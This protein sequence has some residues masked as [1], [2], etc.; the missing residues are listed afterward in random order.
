MTSEPGP[1]E[2]VERIP[3]TAP[4]CLSGGANSLSTAADKWGFGATL[5]EICFDGEAPLQGRGPSE[6]HLRTLGPI[7]QRGLA[8]ARCLESA[9]RIQSCLSS[10]CGGSHMSPHVS[11]TPSGHQSISVNCSPDLIR[12]LWHTPRRSHAS[13]LGRV[14][15][16]M[17]KA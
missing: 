13:V 17:M 15:T 11:G 8:P 5:L 7:P 14:T 16:G 12:S 4:E 6:V 9:F 3:W 10:V 1:P 2:R